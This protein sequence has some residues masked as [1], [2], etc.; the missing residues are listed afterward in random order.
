MSLFSI[1]IPRWIAYPF[2][3]LPWLAAVGVVVWIAGMRFPLNGIFIAESDVTGKS[4]F[5][6]PFLPSERTSSPGEQT[7]GWSGQRIIGD[8]VYMNVRVPGPYPIAEL[9][10]DFRATRQPLVEM[11]MVM[12][13]AGTQLEM[14]PWYSSML[15]SGGWRQTVS[16]KGVH[17]FVRTGVPAARLDDPDVRG[18]AVWLATTTSPL[19]SDAELTTARS[20]G[21]SLRGAHD[22]WA[23]PARGQIDFVFDIQDV[24]RNR[25]GGI[26]AVQVTRDN[27]TVWQDAVGTSGTRDRGYG[28]IIKVAVKLKDLTPGVYRIRL[29][30]DDDVFIRNVATRNSRWVV[31]PR[32]VAGDTVGY[33]TTVKPLVA[34]T[35]ARH[36]V[37]ET[38]HDEGLQ[39]V[40]LNKDKVKIQRTHTAFRLDRTDKETSVVGIIAP[41]G[42][43]RLVS[44]GF[45]ALEQDA[46]FE[47]QPRRLTPETDGIA[48]GLTAVRTDYEKSEDLGDGWR[49][50]RMTFDVPPNAETVRLV[51]GAS[52]IA[53][54]AGSV[55]VRR[56]KITYRRSSM[57]LSNWQSVMMSELRNAWRRL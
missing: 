21:V 9:E 2:L 48:E 32:L 57:S 35:T 45:F 15:E 51:L 53:S 6:Y 47:L 36:V 33:A 49:R 40:T 26:M 14:K 1:Q 34:W 17:G 37:A 52:G 20:I 24:N 10:M 30:G 4:A 19:M 44:D 23:V 41:R 29:M 7:D 22:F 11:G 5:I 50:A 38:F 55:D 13:A 56:I 54:R 12:N 28:S 27:E 8:P 18:M 3:V 42:D 39:E 25:S 46:F 16:P 31:G 43:I